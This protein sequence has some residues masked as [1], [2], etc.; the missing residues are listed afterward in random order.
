MTDNNNPQPADAAS[1]DEAVTAEG[2]SL[3]ILAQ[4]MKDLSFENPNAPKSLGGSEENPEVGVS[5]NVNVQQ[6]GKSEFEVGLHFRVETK[7]GE[8]VSFLTELVYCGLFRALNIPEENLRPVL[9]IEAPRQIFPF[10]RRILS[11][12]TRDGGFPPLMLDPID[13][14]A[15]YQQNA[16][17]EINVGE[18][19]EAP[20][21][22]GT[23]AS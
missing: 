21:Q 4:Y 13:F 14:A 1:A 19:S 11:D 16:A 9:L 18:K 12:V 10:A 8:E 23:D 20:Q 7:R 22:N 15:L 5:V 2:A 6:V 17:N 3:Q